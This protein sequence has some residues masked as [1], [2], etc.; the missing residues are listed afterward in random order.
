[1]PVKEILQILFLAEKHGVPLIMNIIREL[2]K[3][4]EDV[5]YEKVKAEGERR[6]NWG[7]ED[8]PETDPNA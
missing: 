8:L 1:M 2:Q 5:T 6:F 3:T 7:A 4:E